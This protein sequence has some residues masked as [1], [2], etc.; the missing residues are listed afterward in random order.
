[1]ALSTQIAPTHLSMFDEGIAENLDC[2]CECLDK[3]GMFSRTGVL[4]KIT[5]PEY[6]YTLVAKGVQA[7]YADALVREACIYSHC[8]NLQVVYIPVHLGNID[9]VISYPLQSLAY[10]KHMML[11]PWAGMTLEAYIPDGIDIGNE[12]DRTVGKLNS[13][14]ICNGDVRD[15]NLVWNEEVK[16]VMAID[17]DL[18]YIYTTVKR[19]Y[20]S[21]SDE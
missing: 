17:F 7:V 9:L 4:F 19:L 15:T 3:Y 18:A 11:M 10:I 1:M 13:A 2:G 21:A 20:E 8:K 16:G 5:I 12:I 6:G 14:S